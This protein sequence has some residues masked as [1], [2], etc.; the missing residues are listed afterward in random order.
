MDA[1]R[2]TRTDADVDADVD[3]AVLRE[4]AAGAWT[5]SKAAM[6]DTDD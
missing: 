2:T 4:L 1:P 3:V 5:A 6:P